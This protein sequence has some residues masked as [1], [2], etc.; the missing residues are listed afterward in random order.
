[1]KIGQA[2]ADEE[3]ATSRLPKPSTAFEF[4]S[5]FEDEQDSEE[6]KQYKE[7]DAWGDVEDGEA[8]EVGSSHH[9]SPVF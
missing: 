2:L 5:R 8:H 7:D 3:K 9:E 1:L 4:E 6:E